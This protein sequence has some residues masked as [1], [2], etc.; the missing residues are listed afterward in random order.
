MKQVCP[1]CLKSVSVPEDAAG[2]ELNC[3]ECGKSFPAPARYNP[4]VSA[5]PPAAPVPVP[6][7]PVAPAAP[8]PGPVAPAAYTPPPPGLVPTAPAPPA[9]PPEAPPGYTKSFA[10]TLSP[11]VLA[12]LPAVCLS[13]AFLLTFFPWVGSYFGDNAVYSQ[14]PWRM[15]VGSV[16]R[17]FSLEAVASEK[18][19]GF[20]AWLD[21]LPSNWE[22]MLPFLLLLFA[23]ALL[24]WADHLMVA[25]PP[26]NRL[27]PP[28]RGITTM[29]P[30]RAAILFGL[31]AMSLVLVL[32]QA[33]RGFGMES[34]VRQ[35]VKNSP[36]LLEARQKAGGS[37]AD[38]AKVDM[39]EQQKLD[40]YRVRR[41]TWFYLGVGFDVLAVVGLAARA[42]LARRGN[43]PPP[44]IVVQY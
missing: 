33:A 26:P 16:S 34:A 38:Q 23:A 40:E 36:Q 22:L 29:W 41:T 42:G 37:T 7:P 10:I 8:A 35:A 4:V 21:S 6:A 24:A 15:V 13:V 3:P 20:G 32:S 39:M 27:P 14:G 17:D 30:H 12:W 1:H 19:K 18:I 5:P 43:K 44:R 2:K 25:P 9:A 31:A 28:L 11:R